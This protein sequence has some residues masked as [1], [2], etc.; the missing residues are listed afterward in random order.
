M[1]LK[2]AR[3]KAGLTQKQLREILINKYSVSISPVTIVALEKGNYSSL[4]YEKMKALA[5]ALNSTVQELF[6]SEE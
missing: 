1:T 6:F 3:I 5:K 2:I 4:S